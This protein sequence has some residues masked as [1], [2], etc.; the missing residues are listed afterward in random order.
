MLSR[1]DRSLHA[2][3]VLIWA[4]VRER[5]REKFHDFD[6][7]AQL[8]LRAAIGTRKFLELKKPDQNLKGSEF[9]RVTYKIR[10]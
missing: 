4:L 10:P 7:M 3:A 8:F 5:S 9:R 2:G 6:A 1:A